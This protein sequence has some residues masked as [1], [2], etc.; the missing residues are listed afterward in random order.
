MKATS[1]EAKLKKE[2]KQIV[3]AIKQ[4]AAIKRILTGLSEILTTLPHPPDRPDFPS[5]LETPEARAQAMKICE[6]AVTVLRPVLGIKRAQ[7][8]ADQN[9]G[10]I[11]HE[12]HPG[13][14]Q[15]QAET[16]TPAERPPDLDGTKD[17]FE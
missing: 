16:E 8:H 6:E 1:E 9:K 11:N 5:N 17:M 12:K 10:D 14:K 15:P 3:S 2:I 4:W 7:L 13:R